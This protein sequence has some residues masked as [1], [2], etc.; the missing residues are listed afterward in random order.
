[1]LASTEVH[2][3]P[4]SPLTSAVMH[5][6]ASLVDTLQYLIYGLTLPHLP[7]IKAL[8]LVVPL[9]LQAWFLLVRQTETTRFVRLALI[10]FGIYYAYT[11]TLYDFEPRI[12]FRALVCFT[13]LQIVSER[14]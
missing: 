10:P 9:Y 4:S 8:A 5:S 13:I 11:I 14:C 2:P 7:S 3:I 12:P 6:P 1:M